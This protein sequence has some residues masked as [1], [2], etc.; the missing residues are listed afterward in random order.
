MSLRWAVRGARCREVFG[1]A[2]EADGCFCEILWTILGQACGIGAWQPAQ[3]GP[4]VGDDYWRQ[5]YL[6]WDAEPGRHLLACRATNKDGDVQTDVRMR[7]F[8]EG[9]SGLQEISVLIA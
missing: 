6:E 3:L 2:A 1:A 9:S 8:P 7:P 4:E 5:W